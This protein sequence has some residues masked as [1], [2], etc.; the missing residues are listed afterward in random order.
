MAPAFS[1]RRDAILF[2][3]CVILFLIMPVL[4][5]KT[6]NQD[7]R[8]VYPTIPGKNGPYAWFQ[9]KVFTETSDVDV[10]FI[11][12]SLIYTGI[13]TPHVQKAL[14][15]HLGREAEVF[16]LG[17]GWEGFDATYVF[18][19]DLLDHRRVRMLVINDV[20]KTI[21]RPHSLASR[22]FRL[23]EHYNALEGLPL[24][25]HARYYASTVL[26]APRH[27]LS[28]LRPNLV[29]DPALYDLNRFEYRN[30]HQQY[31]NTVESLGGFPVPLAFRFSSNF[32]PYIPQKGAESADT[33]TYSE[34]NREAFEFTGPPLPVSQ[35]HFARKLA[36]LCQER[37][38]HL[39]VLHMPTLNE[40]GRTTIKERVYWP[41]A[42]KAPV[43]IVGVPPARFFAGLSDEDCKK[44]YY[45]KRHMNSN[46][47][48]YF[49]QLIT[50]S[51]IQIYDSSTK[52]P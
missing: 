15:R 28:R 50:P 35:L 45:E 31:L 12:A 30:P 7:R 51:L 8:D 26:G 34:Q 33:L 44:L 39:I 20:S 47:R 4:L 37:G 46:G 18:A 13:D 32:E 48:Q 38:T 3:I 23:D 9:Q 17:F 5:A 52:L 40:S 6:G 22:W 14:S 42:M 24:L 19:R 10:V 11:G 2:A 43:D 1:T 27:L 21:D 25:I 29:Q 16:T 41:D 49:T 36:Q